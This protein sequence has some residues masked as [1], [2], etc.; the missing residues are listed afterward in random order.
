MDTRL[1]FRDH[2]AFLWSD[3]GQYLSRIIGFMFVR[4]RRPAGKSAGLP[5]R[6][7]Q[8]TREDVLVQIGTDERKRT[9]KKNFYD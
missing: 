9:S 5:L 2:D 6:A 8:R 1:I 4:E 7:S 3:E